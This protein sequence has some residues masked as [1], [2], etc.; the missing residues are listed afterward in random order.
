MKQIVFLFALLLLPLAAIA[1]TVEIDGIYY[2][3]ITKAKQADVTSNPNNYS[4]N[5]N[6]P[7]SVIYGGVTYSVTSIGNDAFKNCIGLISLTIPNT[8]TNIGSYAFYNC[9]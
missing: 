4:G 3:L 6:I 5:V 1:E 7:P 2:N 9:I 8:V